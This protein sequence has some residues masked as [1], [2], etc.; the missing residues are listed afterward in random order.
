MALAAEAG[1]SERSVWQG[2]GHYAWGDRLWVVTAVDIRH[3]TAA[4]P[5]KRLVHS[6]GVVKG[7]AAVRG[8]IQL[9]VA[10]CDGGLFMAKTDVLGSADGD[11]GCT[12]SGTG[13][14]RPQQ[15]GGYEACWTHETWLAPG[16]HAV[17]SMATT[18]IARATVTV[19]CAATLAAGVGRGFGHTGSD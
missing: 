3:Q 8:T 14:G 18:P 5:E 9:P 11:A 15:A 10:N 6:C 16:R 17:R 4:E 12:S 19:F 1:Q 7:R 13:S 2:E